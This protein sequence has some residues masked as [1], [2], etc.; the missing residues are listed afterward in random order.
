MNKLNIGCGKDIKEDYINLDIENYKGVN[1][2]WNLNKFPYPFDDDYFDEILGEQVLEHLD[3]PIKVMIELKRIIKD[4][5][6]IIIR[7]PHHAGGNAYADVTHKQFFNSRAFNNLAEK[8]NTILSY[9]RIGFGNSYWDFPIIS[10]IINLHSGTRKLFDYY[11]CYLI[12]PIEV[13]GVFIK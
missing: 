11:L 7:V 9:C 13:E 5:G 12:R 1:V 4:T 10:A 3:D 8:T 6:M 2:V